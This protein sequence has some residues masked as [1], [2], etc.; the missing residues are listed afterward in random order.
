M[1]KQLQ[2]DPIDLTVRQWMRDS[3]IDEHEVAWYRVTKE[4]NHPAEIELRMFVNHPEPTAT[5]VTVS[6]WPV[7]TTLIEHQGPRNG[8]LLCKGDR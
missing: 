8:C 4:H 3:G 7:G 2:G 1:A 6:H 5:E